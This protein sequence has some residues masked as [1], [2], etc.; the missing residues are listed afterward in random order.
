LRFIYLFILFIW[1]SCVNLATKIWGKFRHFQIVNWMQDNFI[2]ATEMSLIF[3]HKKKPYTN[4]VAIILSYP[5]LSTKTM[6]SIT[7]HG[8]A[9]IVTEGQTFS[10]VALM[11]CS[12]F[13]DCCIRWFII[14]PCDTTSGNFCIHE[15]L[16]LEF[17]FPFT[18]CN[19]SEATWKSLWAQVLGFYLCTEMDHISA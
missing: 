8:D 1:F 12:K 2:N 17:S 10:G 3:T 6:H 16:L 5:M 19:F 18:F 15:I 4:M 9:E 14:Q 13:F 11:F 7:W